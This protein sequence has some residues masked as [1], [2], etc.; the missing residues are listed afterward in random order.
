MENKAKL[1]PEVKAVS[2]KYM[3]VGVCFLKTSSRPAPVELCRVRRTV[4][5]GG[6]LA[7]LIGAARQGD[8]TARATGCR[9]GPRTSTA[10]ASTGSLRSSCPARCKRRCRRPLRLGPE[11]EGALS[12]GRCTHRRALFKSPFFC[13]LGIP[14]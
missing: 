4:P 9:D 2:V 10:S 5:V 3:H 11:S 7:G 12:L 14:V 6:H 8:L 1:M 13:P